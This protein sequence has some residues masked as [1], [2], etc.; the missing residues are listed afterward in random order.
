MKAWILTEFSGLDAL[1]LRE[2]QAPAPQ[3]GEVRLR[4]HYAALNP[5]D[6]YLAENQYPAKPPLPHVLGRDGVGEV[7]S[8]G[9]GVTDWK[10]G[11]V[12]VLLRGEV[13]VNRWGTFAELVNVPRDYLVRLPG[14]Q[15]GQQD[16]QQGG[17]SEQE[18]A[19]APLVYLTAWQAI[20]QWGDLPTQPVMLVSGASGGVGVA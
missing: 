20:T 8:L 13:G 2:V 6:G 16:G 15:Q 5:A 3:A 9:A 19:G 7:E 4:V 1:E 11:D 10:I 17:W 18:A 14:G 12:A